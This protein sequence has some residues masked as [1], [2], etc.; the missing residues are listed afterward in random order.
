MTATAVVCD[1]VRAKIGSALVA[2]I[3]T[4]LERLLQIHSLTLSARADR[5][6]E[7]RR[8]VGA[9]LGADH[10]CIDAA[11]EAVSELVT[12]A[13]L[14]GS[15]D[16]RATVTLRVRLLRRRRVRLTVSDEGGT[17]H[18]PAIGRPEGDA[19]K[20]RGL[21]IV[22]ALAS[23]LYWSRQGSGHK[24]V[25]LLDPWRPGPKFAEPASVD[26]DT[27]ERRPFRCV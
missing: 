5:V 7:A 15:R 16:Q 22:S 8:Y 3:V 2:L 9:A 11:T 21:L 27:W 4:R 23:R 13:I 17:G 24:V 1:A 19:A 25:A 6:R 10:P 12:N 14:H 26:L 18:V 20:G